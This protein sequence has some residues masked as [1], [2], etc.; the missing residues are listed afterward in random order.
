MS[1]HRSQSTKVFSGHLKL[2]AVPYNQ[3]LEDTS[4][5]EFDTMADKLEANVSWTPDDDDDTF[6]DMRFKLEEHPSGQVPCV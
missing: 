4:S 6:N 3:R 5:R 1:K 2:V